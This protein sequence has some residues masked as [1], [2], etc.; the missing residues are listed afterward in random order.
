MW[1]LKEISLNW[2]AVGVVVVVGGVAVGVAVCVVVVVVV[3]GDIVGILLLLLLLGLHVCLF[4]C[5][6]IKNNGNIENNNKLKINL[7]IT[8]KF[9]KKNLK[10]TSKLRIKFIVTSNLT[11]TLEKNFLN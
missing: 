2:C 3:V 1:T 10:I 4:R 11:I 7:M 6:I 5:I 8:L 9:K